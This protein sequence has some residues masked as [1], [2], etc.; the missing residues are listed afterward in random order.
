M[1]RNSSRA[2]EGSAD[3]KRRNEGNIRMR[4]VVVLTGGRREG[5]RRLAT[6]SHRC[7]E[8]G[9]RYARRE[10]K[11]VGLNGNGEGGVERRR[12]CGQGGAQRGRG[13]RR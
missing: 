5:S 3:L 11:K 12:R 13:S 2:S 7:L 1:E 4:E 9:R 6:W 8:N 10:E